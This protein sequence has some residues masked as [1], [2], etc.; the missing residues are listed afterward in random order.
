MYLLNCASFLALTL[1]L[2]VCQH[3]PSSI[4]MFLCVSGIYKKYLVH[5]ALMKAE[6]LT[7]PSPS[8]LAHFSPVLGA[9]T[10]PVGVSTP[11]KQFRNVLM[12]LK[13]PPKYLVHGTLVE[14]EI[15][16]SPLLNVFA[17]LCLVFS[18]DSLPAGVSTPPK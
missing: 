9:S 18:T 2:H 3:L 5:G 6:I 16:T 12:C 1:Y 7:S 4:E 15:L 11:P 17:Q 13:N 8:V 10:Q 14:A